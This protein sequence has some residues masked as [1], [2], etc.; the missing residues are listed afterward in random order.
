MVSNGPKHASEVATQHAPTTEMEQPLGF[1][2]PA[3][4]SA[5]ASDHVTPSANTPAAAASSEHLPDTTPASD[6]SH[7]ELTSAAHFSDPQGLSNPDF[8]PLSDQTNDSSNPFDS[9]GAL[10]SLAAAYDAL[11]VGSFSLPS[12]TAAADTHAAGVPFFEVPASE[13]IFSEAHG[14]GGGTSTH[15]HGGGGTTTSPSP[16]P[17]GLVINVTYDASVGSAPSGFTTVV[18]QVVQY[19]ESHFTDPVQIN[20]HVG[21]GEVG[22]QSLGGALGESQTYL[23]TE[24][25]SALKSA[26]SADAST[27]TDLSA[28]A[29]LPSFDPYGSGTYYVSTAEAKALG[30]LSATSTNVDGNI[31]FSSAAGIFDYNN[32]DGVTSGQYDFFGVVAHEISEVMGRI[33]MHGGSTGANMLFDLFHYSAPGVFDGSGSTPGYFSIDGGTTSLNTFNTNS[34][35]DAGDW[36]G[37]TVDAF[38]AFGS[39]GA[40]MPISSADLTALDAIGWNGG[41]TTTTVSSGSSSLLTMAQ[42]ENQHPTA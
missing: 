35:G 2:T 12:A 36:A 41:S 14:S 20:L 19:F 9:H 3:P 38:N 30:L 25:Y 15:G 28:S 24:S 31:G 42:L 23:M 27:S 26:L 17:T 4:S 11:D 29:S 10:D 5:T 32:T 33:L 21:Y 37:K 16:S 6:T 13:F 7:P 39:P 18:G 22:G 8:A 1:D 40:V 34:G